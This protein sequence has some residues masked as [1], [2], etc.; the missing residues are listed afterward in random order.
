MHKVSMAIVVISTGGT[1]ASTSN[2][3][4][5]A[6]PELTG[7]DLV[8][9]VPEIETVAAL[10]TRDFSNVPSTHF[11]VDQMADLADVI[12][13]LNEDD[14]VSGVVVTQG[15]DVLE[16]S[17]YFVD[18]C[19]EGH[20]PVVF[21]GAMRTS[22]HPSADGPGNLLASVRVAAS[23]EAYG[24]GVLVTFNDR[25]H[26]AREATKTNSMNMDTFR[27]PE[28]G[29]L[30]VVD[31]NRVTW[32]RHSGS[33]DPQFDTDWN[34]L[35]NDVPV[36]YATADMSQR[37]LVDGDGVDAVC[38][39]ATGAGHIPPKTIPWL[40]N[41]RDESVPVIATTRCLE[42]RLARSTYGFEGSEATLRQFDCYYSDLNIQKTRIQ[43]I[44][45]LSA[46]S[47]D[48]AFDRP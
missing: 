4:D 14:D 34:N 19:Y 40:E 47:L 36:I 8:E 7:D 25:V 43:A 1:I 17:A 48:D 22:S 35:T 26:T 33:P 29:P 30:A 37:D 16:E 21:T 42:G 46:R 3:G 15:T 9:A 23:E 41:L 12:T 44:V 5:D 39:A 11:T 31:E 28:F 10:E 18:L 24:R 20:M 27:S 38:L 32:R 13:E 2:D 45:A 6:S